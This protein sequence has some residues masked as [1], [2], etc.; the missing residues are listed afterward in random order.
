MQNK[1][2][3]FLIIISTFLL[4]CEKQNNPQASKTLVFT[5]G[6]IY[7]VNEK[8]PWASAIVIK[9]G[10]IIHVGSDQEALKFKDSQTKTV[11][12]NGKMMLPG[13]HD[14]HVHP[15]HG[16]VT[17]LQ[18][19]LSDIKGVDKLLSKIK[20]C[21]L[22]NKNSEWVLGGGWSVDNFSASMLPDK[23]LLDTIIPDRPV[24]LKSSDGHS[25]WVNSKALEIAKINK[26][27]IDPKNGTIERYPNSHE[28]TGLLHEDSAMMMVMDNHPQL[29][30]KELI[31]GLIFSRDL[32]HSLGITGV[33]DAILKLDPGDPY[34]GLDA[35]NHLESKNELNLH[36]VLAMLW[37]NA[38]PLSFQLDRFIKIREQQKESK[39]I[40]ATAIKIW[41]D[42][43]IE[44]YTA[45]MIEPY[46]DRKD[47][48]RGELQNTPEA[49]NQAITALDAQNFQIH[50]HAIGDRAIQVSFDALEKARN[51]NGIRDSRHHISHI[52]VFQEKDISRFKELDVV[53]NFQPLW[54]IQDEYI[55]EHTW[56]KIGKKRSR[57]L[58]PI[59]SV[60]RTGAKIG[61]GSDWYV[62]SVN[63]LDGIEAAVSRLEPNG[64]TEIPLGENEE[65]DL[66]SAIKAYTLNGAYVNFLDHLVGS[67]EVGKQADLVILEDNLFEIPTHKINETKVT[68]TLFNGHLVYGK[69]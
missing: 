15:V 66:A 37:K 23:S 25:L 48:F 55:T 58:Y 27:T 33:Q 52:Q 43:V 4:A 31:A 56:S 14:I 45:A 22:N 63:P 1:H 41:Q 57:W 16:G 19:N 47:G 44:T 10:K 38:Q 28:P 62:T 12:L 51:I 64:L 2:L 26:N 6:K 21:A 42:G 50:F 11:N 29:T 53:A 35:Y 60:Q 36:V 34:Y 68:A 40:Q 5:N 65:I 54:A 39:N 18:C 61:F 30:Q 46:S 67:I 13:F 59:G 7:T 20:S 8:Q 17:Y 3:Y 9:E 49:L 32:F 69:L 24:S